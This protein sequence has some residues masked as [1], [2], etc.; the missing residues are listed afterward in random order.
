MTALLPNQMTKAGRKAAGIDCRQ[1]GTPIFNGKGKPQDCAACEEL[2]RFDHSRRQPAAAAI[3][4]PPVMSKR[5]RKN[6]TGPNHRIDQVR[7]RRWVE[8]YGVLRQCSPTHWQ[9]VGDF[10]RLDWWP[11]KGKWSIGNAPASA[12]TLE[13]M[14]KAIEAAL[15][16][17]AS[18]ANSAT[19]GGP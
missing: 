3:A 2:D 18:G 15:D 13:E 10:G 9:L 8:E 1:C 16:Y 14:V 4:A 6:L 19:G 5:Q 12:G 17:A 7:V 11:A